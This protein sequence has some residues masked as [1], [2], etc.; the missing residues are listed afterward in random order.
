MDHTVEQG[1]QP[2]RATR[3]RIQRVKTAPGARHARTADP[4]YSE[5]NV[6]KQITD[7][8]I[9]NV[10]I[11]RKGRPSQALHAEEHEKRSAAP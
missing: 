9:A 11:P 7:L 4:G 3:P 1:N 6:D 5:A 2:T 10:V 8:I